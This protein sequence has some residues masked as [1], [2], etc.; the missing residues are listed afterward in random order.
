[1]NEDPLPVPDGM[2]PWEPWP[3]RLAAALFLAKLRDLAREERAIE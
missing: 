3:P 1:V 2:Q